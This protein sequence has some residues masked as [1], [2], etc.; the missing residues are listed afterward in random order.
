MK[1]THINGDA[2]GSYDVIKFAH[3]DS[4]VWISLLNTRL[5]SEEDYFHTYKPTDNQPEEPLNRAV[6]RQ[7][8]YSEM[9]ANF[10][11]TIDRM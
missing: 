1:Q 10:R 11:E 2:D 6:K 7:Q 9:P 5:I 3:E 4:G 8:T